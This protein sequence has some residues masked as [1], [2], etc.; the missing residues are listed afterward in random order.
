MTTPL[1]SPLL[2]GTNEGACETTSSTTGFFLGRPR[3]RL[4]GA[5]SLVGAARRPADA[6]FREAEA[7]GAKRSWV[8]RT[9]FVPLLRVLW[10]SRENVV[11]DS[12]ASNSSFSAFRC[13]LRAG[14]RELEAAGEAALDPSP[15]DL[16]ALSSSKS[17]FRASSTG[18]QLANVR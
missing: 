1:K 4:G 6:D 16:S 11:G 14:A 17:W 8:T 2:G 18:V 3:F 10:G 5:V 15:S 9:R 12:A 7:E 13:L